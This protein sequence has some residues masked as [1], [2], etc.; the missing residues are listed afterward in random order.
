MQ[1]PWSESD[2]LDIVSGMVQPLSS[3]LG[4][5]QPSFDFWSLPMLVCMREVLVRSPYAGC[6]M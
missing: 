2:S 3:A 1:S 6:G 4:T 5:A